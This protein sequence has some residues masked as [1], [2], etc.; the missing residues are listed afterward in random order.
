VFDNAHVFMAEYQTRLD[1][2]ATFI[3]MKI[4]A[5]NGSG[6]DANDRI[7]RLY[8]DRIVDGVDR[9]VVR[10]FKNDCAHES[11]PEKA[12][13]A[14]SVIGIRRIMQSRRLGK[15]DE[16]RRSRCVLGIVQSC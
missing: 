12:W 9:H 5:A 7:G 8:D 15:H 14:L 13:W 4:A 6:R 1:G 11:S 3:H 10:L 16:S 2:R